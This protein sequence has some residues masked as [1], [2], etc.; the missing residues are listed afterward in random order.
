MYRIRYICTMNK[1]VQ[2]VNEWAAYEQ[3]HS[4]ADLE[5]FCRYYLTVQRSKR[6]VGPNFAGGGV[7]PHPKSFLMKLIGFLCRA[8]S[9]FYEKAFAHI[10]EIRQKEDFY[11]LNIILNKDESRKTE[12]IIAQML[13]MTTGIDTLN[14]LLA[15][16]LIQER[17]DP[18]DK[19][20]KLLSIT[21]QG[22]E[23]LG[24]CYVAAQK[25]NDAILYGLSDEDIRLCIQLLREVEA[26]QSALVLE[27]L[28]Q[29]IEAFFERMG[30]ESPA[31]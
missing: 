8:S 15:A 27:L 12:V 14:R 24:R 5:D 10:P 4:N 17:P 20:A 11:L 21:E 1:T 28:D 7:P 22:R 19:R 31:Y 2:L 18:T 23:V 29:P 9:V 16:G 25:V 26:R 13:G 3:Q 30:I 6:E